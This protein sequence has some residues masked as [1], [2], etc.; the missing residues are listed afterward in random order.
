M[1]TAS[2]MSGIAASQDTG[3]MC[4][5]PTKLATIAPAAR[6]GLIE[7]N[8]L[9]TSRLPACSIEAMLKL[10]R[11]AAMAVIVIVVHASM[12][13]RVRRPIC[14]V[15]PAGRHRHVCYSSPVAGESSPDALL[16]K[17]VRVVSSTKHAW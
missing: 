17:S 11:L 16:G 12:R 8:A 2:R 1:I 7:P 9:L 3:A 13:G 5:L 15:G 10:D 4:V 6:R 14:V